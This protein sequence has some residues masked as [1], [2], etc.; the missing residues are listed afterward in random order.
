MEGNIC[1]CIY[2][3][4]YWICSVLVTGMIERR[5]LLKWRRYL[6][7][8]LRFNSHLSSL[9]VVSSWYT[10]V[11][12]MFANGAVSCIHNPTQMS[13]LPSVQPFHAIAYPLDPMLALDIRWGFFLLFFFLLV[14]HSFRPNLMFSSCSRKY[15][16]H[17]SVIASRYSLPPFSHPPPFPLKGGRNGR[18]RVGYVFWI[19]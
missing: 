14:W 3:C 8:R 15:A 13:V 10:I 16:Q 5:C 4:W 19:V 6:E 1:K 17:C 12:S 11:I 9:Y 2:L 18:L 7:D